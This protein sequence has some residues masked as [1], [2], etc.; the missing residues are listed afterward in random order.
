MDMLNVKKIQ[1]VYH[2]SL[3]VLGHYNATGQVMLYL[4]PP[5]ALKKMGGGEGWTQ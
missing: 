2:K 5:F 4:T 3:P 1:K